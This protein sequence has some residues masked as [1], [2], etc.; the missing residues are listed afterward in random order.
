MTALA[1]YAAELDALVRD[2][3]R[4]RL[5]DR[6]IERPHA[7]LDELLAGLRKLADRMRIDGVEISTPAYDRGTWEGPHVVIT[8]I[9]QTIRVAARRQR[10]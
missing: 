5:G 6:D 10:A 8:G 3:R 7:Q 2:G 9:A 1:Q 4:I